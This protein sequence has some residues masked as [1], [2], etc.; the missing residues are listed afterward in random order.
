MFGKLAAAFAIASM[1]VS[2][3]TPRLTVTPRGEDFEGQVEWGCKF[4][5]VSLVL[6]SFEV[7]GIRPNSVEGGLVGESLDL[8]GSERRTLESFTFILGELLLEYVDR[9]CTFDAAFRADD[10]DAPESDDEPIL[11]LRVKLT[12][13]VTERRTWLF[14]ALAFYPG[15][16]LF[17]PITPQ[18]GEARA[19]LE[20][21]TTD[22]NGAEVFSTTVHVSAP[23]DMFF[24]SWLRTRPVEAALRRA[25]DGALHEAALAFVANRER[26]NTASHLAP[27]EQPPGG[28]EIAMSDQAPEPSVAPDRTV[29]LDPVGMFYALQWPSERA[30]SRSPLVSYLQALGGVRFSLLQGTADV[31]SSTQD[32]NGASQEVA[33]GHASSSGYRLSFYS[34]PDR[35]GYFV[36]PTVDWMF[37]RIDIADFRADL[38]VVDVPGA[39]EISAVFTDPE[40]GTAI[41]ITEPNVYTLK[42]RSIAV[43]QRAGWDL[44]IASPWIRMFLTA[45][46]GLNILERRQSDVR[47]GLHREVGSEWVWLGS[48]AATGRIG[49]TH[50][51]YHVALTGTAEA[52]YYPRFDYPNPVEFRGTAHYNRDKLVFERPRTW[53]NAAGLITTDLTFSLSYVF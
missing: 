28:Q 51:R 22:T 38:P 34:A 40:T 12:P 6:E 36:Y 46:G 44:V 8:T 18:W 39:E 31:S 9:V 35:S 16:V 5:G 30:S 53:V 21:V 3:V 33:S 10:E 23:Y 43:G 24:Y 52:R 41:D 13:K 29:R 11:H 17:Q 19:N 47:L 14:D 4:E 26:I 42:L 27:R 15:A 2:C 25:Y 7:V 49:F 20:V 1:A 50:P 48:G 37:Q 32:E 45:E